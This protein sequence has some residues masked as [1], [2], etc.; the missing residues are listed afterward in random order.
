MRKGTL[1]K[2]VRQIAAVIGII[3]LFGMY[4]VTFIAAM[5]R[6]DTARSL[7]LGSLACTV[8]VPVFLYVLL[9]AAKVIKPD[10]S[11]VVDTIIFDVGGVLVDFP[12][13]RYPYMI[14]ISDDAREYIMEHVIECGIWAECDLGN[15][16]F[17]A[18]VQKFIALGPQYA[19]EIREL[20]ET[21][22]TCITVKPFTESWIRGLKNKGYRV[23][24]LSNWSQ[25]AYEKCTENG[26]LDFTRLTDGCLWS[27]TVHERKPDT[28]IYRTLLEKYKIDPKRA[29]FI[30]DNPENIS[31]ARKCGI[32]GILYESYEKT[33]ARLADIGVRV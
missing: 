14:D 23:Y 1:M 29:V 7:F 28:Q 9:L 18:L 2:K 13:I 11:P 30:D 3:L 17:E 26:V 25:H 24:I 33:V 8:L 15:E 32:G 6:S 21:M 12:W 5:G 31:A 10:K 27:F 16:S 22:Y 4:A 20:I 19:E